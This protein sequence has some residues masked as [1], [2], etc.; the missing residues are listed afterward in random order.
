VPPTKPS[1]ELLRSIT[2]ESVL[3][4]LMEE[5]RMTRAEIAVRTGI[6]KTTI[7]ESMRRL[8][9][10]GMVVDTGERTSGRGR[11]G[12]YYALAEGMGCALVASISPAG[13]VAEA[14]DAVGH[15][16]ARAE[17]PLERAAGKARAAEVLGAAARQV[18]DAAP[19]D[20][21][22]SVVSAADPVDRHTGRLVQLPDAPFLVGD[23]D[24]VAILASEVGGEVLVDNDVNW[25]ARAERQSGSAVDVDDF[26]YVHLGEGLGCAVVSDGKVRRGHRGVAGEIA[27]VLT[28]GPSGSTVPFTEVFAELGLRRPGSTAIDVDALRAAVQRD[29]ALAERVVSGLADAVSGVLMAAIAFGDPQLVVLGGSWAG[30]RP[31]VEALHER[32]GTWPRR[33]PVEVSALPEAPELVAAR[34]QAV[35]MLRSAIVETAREGTV[36]SERRE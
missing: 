29:D 5:G 13:V 3:R 27:H 15:V 8:G 9:A 35:E 16:V 18:R 34:G 25:A 10:A 12:L 20:V 6:S 4:L 28:R 33:L 14:V 21:R 7:S 26:V 36:P 32:T 1:L 17:L 24:P 11:S 2:D 22:A 23:L 31:F 19:G 30:L